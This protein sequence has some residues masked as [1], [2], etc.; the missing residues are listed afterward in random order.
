MARIG[1]FVGAHDPNRTL[2][3]NQ[4]T[5]LRKMVSELKV[6]NRSVTAE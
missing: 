2:W 6:L 5:E 3:Q 4:L 1:L